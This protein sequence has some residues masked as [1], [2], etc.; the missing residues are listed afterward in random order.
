[1]QIDKQL[2]IVD[3]DVNFDLHIHKN[4]DYYLLD[5]NPHPHKIKINQYLYDNVE[6][7]IHLIVLNYE[8]YTKEINIQAYLNNN[9][10]KAI[11]YVQVIGFNNSQTSVFLNAHL[12][13]KCHSNQVAQTIKAT[14]LNNARVQGQPTLTIDSND[15]KA[16]HAYEVGN[17]PDDVLF[18][19][20]LKGLSKHDAIYLIV[21]AMFNQVLNH[22]DD[23]IKNKYW[24]KIRD[25]FERI[26]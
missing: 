26:I 19:L 21:T 22:F 7:T 15:V 25:T 6:S 4:T 23:D 3:Q 24:Q 5:L 10:A 1:M 13:A 2:I 17:I 18:Y 9:F 14:L 16:S 12:H 8:N 11:N 20:K